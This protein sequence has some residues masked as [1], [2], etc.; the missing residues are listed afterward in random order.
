MTIGRV[1]VSRVLP[2]P[3]L[4]ADPLYWAGR[5]GP[6]K[7]KDLIL[8]DDARQCEGRDIDNVCVFDLNGR[9]V[10]A[11]ARTRSQHRRVEVDLTLHVQLPAFRR[12]QRGASWTVLTSGCADARA[13]CWLWLCPRPFRR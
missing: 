2:D 4:S 5:Q 13:A 12:T 1:D 6:L 11:Q 10:L 3:I 9:A 8:Y 7:S